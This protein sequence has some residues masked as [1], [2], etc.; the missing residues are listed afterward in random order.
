MKKKS[1]MLQIKRQK[2]VRTEKWPVSVW[3]LE[4]SIDYVE[5]TEIRMLENGV[6]KT[7]PLT[8]ATF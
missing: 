1:G 4:E 5:N 2:Q 3:E 8:W 6:F 7:F